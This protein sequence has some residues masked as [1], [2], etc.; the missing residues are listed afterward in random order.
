M[1]IKHEEESVGD[2]WGSMKEE[3]RS[4]QIEL[5]KGE[6]EGGGGEQMDAPTSVNRGR[7]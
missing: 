7:C 2:P 4:W 1:L 3:N 5:N 6:R